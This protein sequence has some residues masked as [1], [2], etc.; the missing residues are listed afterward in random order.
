MHIKG[1]LSHSRGV[2]EMFVIKVFVGSSWNV[3]SGRWDCPGDCESWA[4]KHIPAWLAYTIE[5]A[6]VA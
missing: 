1:Y 3:L 4:D 2:C 6:S 5:P